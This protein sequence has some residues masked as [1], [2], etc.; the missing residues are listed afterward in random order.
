LKPQA[1]VIFVTFAILTASPATYSFDGSRKGFV[2]GSGIGFS[3][4]V[5]LKSDSLTDELGNGSYVNDESNRGLALDFIIG[6]A[7]DEHNMIV[8]EGNVVGYSLESGGGAG[9]TEVDVYQ[10]FFGVSWYHYFGHVGKSAFVAGGLGRYV[11]IIYD[12]RAL[13]RLNQISGALQIS[14]GYEFA[15]HLQFGGYLGFK[16]N[17]LESKRLHFSI[18]VGCIAF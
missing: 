13:I 9:R 7:W 1:F 14:V 11:S 3:P 8:Y 12:Q 17:P 6:Y 4:I 16:G 15:R 2:L 10:G 18:L 5:T